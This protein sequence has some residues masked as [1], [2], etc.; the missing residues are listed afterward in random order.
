ML[1]SIEDSAKEGVNPMSQDL[2]NE[3]CLSL[4][5]E[6]AIGIDLQMYIP[7]SSIRPR[8]CALCNKHI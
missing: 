7:G 8:E 4:V 2:I 6:Q 1:L 5:A 3:V